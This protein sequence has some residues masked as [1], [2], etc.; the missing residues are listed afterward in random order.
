MMAPVLSDEPP[1]EGKEGGG[2]D[3][4]GGGVGGGEGG[5]GATLMATVCVTCATVGLTAETVTPA[6]AREVVSAAGLLAA[7]AAAFEATLAACP[8]D[9]S[10]AIRRP[11]SQHRKHGSLGSHWALIGLSLGSHWAPIALPLCS[12]CALI[13]FNLDH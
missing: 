8:N 7:N 3:G 12:H 13:R 2:S 11:R 6:E 9:N 1:P 5:G 4:D 10:I